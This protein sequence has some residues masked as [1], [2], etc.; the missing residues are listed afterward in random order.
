[1]SGAV[2]VSTPWVH[3]L[4]E[5]GVFVH[6]GFCRESLS[7]DRLRFMAVNSSTRLSNFWFSSHHHSSSS[8]SERRKFDSRQKGPCVL[9]PSSSSCG[10]SQKRERNVLQMSNLWCSQLETFPGRRNYNIIFHKSTYEN[11][12]KVSNALI[13]NAPSED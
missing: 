2:K 12:E 1:V 7:D 8:K 5:I 4:P 6:V 3:E 13:S 11:R 9:V 10:N